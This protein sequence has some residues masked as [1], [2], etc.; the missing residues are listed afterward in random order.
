[1]FGNADEYYNDGSTCTGRI[2]VD[3]D[4]KAT[5]TVEMSRYD[6]NTKQM[7]TVEKSVRTANIGGNKFKAFTEAAI[8]DDFIKTY[9]EGMQM[10]TSNF[11]ISVSQ[12]DR[13]KK[14]SGNA[15]D[16]N[17]RP[18]SI[19]ELFKKLDGETKWKKIE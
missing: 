11:N 7:K 4:G 16:K 15:D 3:R 5:K 13:T 10:S 14:F 8:N 12:G 6:K 18:I 9:P 2:S 1:L 17:P 19:I